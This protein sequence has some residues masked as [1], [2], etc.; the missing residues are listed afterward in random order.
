[1][2]GAFK[3]SFAALGGRAWKRLAAVDEVVETLAASGVSFKKL[4]LALALPKEHEMEP[5]DKYT[6]FSKTAKNYRKGVHKVPKFTKNFI[7]R[8]SP[9][10]F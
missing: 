3:P 2:F 4:D 6:T 7:P 9:V 10:G 8:F 1:M 5:R